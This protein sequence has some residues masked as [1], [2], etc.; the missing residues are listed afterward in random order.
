MSEDV[1]SGL[2]H[3]DAPNAGDRLPIGTAPGT[4]GYSRRDEFAYKTAGGNFVIDGRLNVEGDQTYALVCNRASGDDS[5]LIAFLNDGVE[6]FWFGQVEWQDSGNGIGLYNQGTGDWAWRVSPSG[7]FFLNSY[8]LNITAPNGGFSGITLRKTTIDT[9]HVSWDINHR[10][11]NKDL[12]IFGFDG[13]TY[14]NFL[15][16]DWDNS[17]VEARSS[18]IP[19]TDNSFTNGSGSNRWSVIYAATGTINTSDDTEKTWR[20]SPSTAEIAAARRIISELGFFQWNDAIEEKGD[21]ARYHFGVRAQAVWS[22]MADEGLIG[23]MDESETPDSA[24]A[25]LCYDEWD[26]LPPQGEEPGR[27]A[28]SRF[29]IRPDQ[30]ALFLI[31]A[32]EARIAA[33]EA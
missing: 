24:Y 23:A 6:K 22:I 28:G 7:G 32:Q 2:G 25:F 9:S 21:G 27:T 26:A 18:F 5:N 15:F 11:N 16:F 12:L 14:R 13:S 4:G 29:G 3:I 33:L 19:G 8:N 10:D 31:A 20:G 1:Y 30:L 17:R